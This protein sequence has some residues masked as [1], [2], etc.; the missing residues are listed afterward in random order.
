VYSAS[1]DSNHVY[2]IGA[3]SGNVYQDTISSTGTNTWQ[4]LGG[5]LQGGLNALYFNPSTGTKST[6]AGIASL[7]N[8][9]VGKGAG[10]C[11]TANSSN[12]SL[13]GD[14]FYTSCDGN[15]G[16]AEYWCADF[17]MWVWANNGINITGLNAGAGSFVA[18]A[19]DNGSTVHTATSY[20]PQ[21]GD[22]VV[23]NYSG[24]TASHVGIVTAVNSD[25]SIVTDNGDFGGTSSVESTFAEQ[26]T[27]EQVTISA[28]QTAVGDTPSSIGMTISAYV[29][30]AGL[31]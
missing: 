4:N 13:G 27:V 12:N 3:T 20:Q 26:S 1:D 8:A 30:P 2:A 14:D 19:S 28:G 7:A 6:A 16:S 10:Y 22:A 29:T 5:T 9:N 21:V 25:G 23:Y 11:S 18:D 24:G 31:S 17:A 15:N